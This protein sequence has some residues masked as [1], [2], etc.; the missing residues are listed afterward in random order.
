MTPM[1]WTVSY[2][3]PLYYKKCIQNLKGENHQCAYELNLYK[4]Y[5]I[6]WLCSVNH[7]VV[8]ISWVIKTSVL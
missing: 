7:A 5:K 6:V 8:G 3:N 2:P 4:D 1:K